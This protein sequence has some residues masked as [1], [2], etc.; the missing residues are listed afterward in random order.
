MVPV[1]IPR[2]KLS[3]RMALLSVAGCAALV[4]LAPLSA[5]AGFG[6]TPPEEIAPAN[7]NDDGVPALSEDVFNGPL[8][9][10]PGAAVP[11]EPV[12]NVSDLPVPNEAPAL[13]P[14]DIISSP[15]PSVPREQVAAPSAKPPV[16]IRRNRPAT[17]PARKIDPV[18]RTNNEVVWA[19]RKPAAP[20]PAPT[21]DEPVFAQEPV[22]EAPAPQMQA[23]PLD[24]TVVQGFGRDI[25]L[26]IALRQIAPSSYAYKFADGVSPGQK[27]S[28]EGGKPWPD[29]LSDMLAANGLQVVILGHVITVE[30]SGAPASRASAPTYSRSASS[31][32]EEPTSLSID[33]TASTSPTAR[34]LEQQERGDLSASSSHASSH[35]SSYPDTQ[36]VAVG[37]A[38]AQAPVVDIQNRRRWEA[39]PGATLRE[40]LEKWAKSAGAELEWMTPY[41]YPIKNTFAFQGR[42]DQA[43]NSLLGSYSRE[44]Q[45]P[46]GRLYPNLPEGPSVLMIN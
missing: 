1:Q 8:T 7:V 24:Q 41:D 28:W 42:F 10:E 45:R 46:R 2:K 11:V 17:P 25:S 30:N 3:G 5:Q 37:G 18:S 14:S 27:V 12:Q 44:E 36:V 20:A 21:Y 16:E 26:A 9:P 29:V 33:D 19:E 31:L 15:A 23:A 43:V 40:T 6:W 32:V 35:S 13:K 39:M 38:E 22:E 34:E 4:F